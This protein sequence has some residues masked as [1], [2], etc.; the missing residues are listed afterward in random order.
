MLSK[1]SKIAL[2]STSLAPIFLTIWF[3]KLSED[4][5]VI[6]GWEYIAITVFLVIVCVVLLNLSKSKLEKIPLKIISV[7]TVDIEVVGFILVYLFPLI[8]QKSENIN[9]TLLIFIIAL[10]LMIVFTTNSYHFNPLLGFFGYHFYEVTIEGNVTF[11]LITK[12]NI[13]NCK[14]ITS[15]VQISEYMLLETG[16]KS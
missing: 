8:C 2:V 12:R 5:R 11:V 9:A 16:E 7:K 14:N 6:D 3:I 4:W 10:Y 15:A 13:Y 1:F